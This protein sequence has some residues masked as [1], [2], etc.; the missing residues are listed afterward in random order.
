LSDT[1]TQMGSL[2]SKQKECKSLSEENYD[3][4]AVG[5]A[6]SPSFFQ[7]LV[8]QCFVDDVNRVDFATPD[9]MTGKISCMGLSVQT[10]PWKVALLVG[11]ALIVSLLFFWVLTKL[12]RKHKDQIL[13]GL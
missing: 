1:K 5:R 3:Y 8:V 12:T 6:G 11:V 7:R 2:S 13:A 4:Y 9:W 10:D